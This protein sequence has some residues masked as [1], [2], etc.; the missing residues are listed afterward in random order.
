MWSWPV[1]GSWWCLFRGTGKTSNVIS[2]KFVSLRQLENLHSAVGF[3]PQACCLVLFSN[4]LHAVY[5][6]PAALFAYLGVWKGVLERPVGVMEELGRVHQVREP[7]SPS[8]FQ[9]NRW[10]VA[11][12][13]WGCGHSSLLTAP[14]FTPLPATRSLWH[15]PAHQ[16][17]QAH[18]TLLVDESSHILWQLKIV[19]VLV[20]DC[21]STEL[22]YGNWARRW[23]NKIYVDL[24]SQKSLI[25]LA[26]SISTSPKGIW[27]VF[28]T[29][30]DRGRCFP[31]LYCN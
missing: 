1:A 22:W 14:V 19:S 6:I 26:S 8:P 7:Q 3:H 29:A 27:E 17:V 12:R 21:I 16:A 24:F 4:L 25:F 20:R 28:G 31:S 18:W 2:L 13:C 9:C 23:I 11:V 30:G 15:L 5:Y 10:V